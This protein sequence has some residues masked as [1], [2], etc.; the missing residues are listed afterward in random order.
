MFAGRHHTS[1]IV[2]AHDGSSAVHAVL[3]VHAVSVDRPDFAVGTDAGASS[4]LQSNRFSGRRSTG[5]VA[6]RSR[7]S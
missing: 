4:A 6:N 2:F 7:L 3:D 1:S 5:I